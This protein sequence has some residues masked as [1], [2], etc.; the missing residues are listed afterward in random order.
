MIRQGCCQ[1]VYSFNIPIQRRWVE[2][3]DGWNLLKCCELGLNL[4]ALSLEFR[5]PVACVIL[6]NDV[7]DD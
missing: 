5:D 7:L 6:S 2:R 1:S 3:Y 4:Q